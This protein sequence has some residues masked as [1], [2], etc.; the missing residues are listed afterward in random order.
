MQQHSFDDVL[1][2]QWCRSSPAHNGWW[3]FGLRPLAKAAQV[4]SCWSGVITSDQLRQPPIIGCTHHAVIRPDL[5]PHNF[6]GLSVAGGL[7]GGRGDQVIGGF[8]PKLSSD[9]TN[10]L[11]L[12]SKYIDN[13][14]NVILCLKENYG[15]IFVVVVCM[16][17]IL[18]IIYTNLSKYNEVVKPVLFWW[19]LQMVMSK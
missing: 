9:C 2:A 5:H 11:C 16:M 10:I 1:F 6:S 8:G 14:V 17:H 3:N 7:R 4:I 19:K 18:Y 15:L 12:T 13:I